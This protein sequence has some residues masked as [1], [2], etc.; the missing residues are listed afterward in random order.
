MQLLTM[1]YQSLRI[2]IAVCY[3]TC[4]NKRQN[5]PSVSV[6]MYNHRKLM[7]RDPCF[8]SWRKPFTCRWS[9]LERVTSATNIWASDS[10]FYD[11]CE[12][13]FNHFCELKRVKVLHG[14][15]SANKED[16]F[17]RHN[18][19]LCIMVPFMSRPN[20]ANLKPTTEKQ[21]NIVF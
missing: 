11:R 17:L 13:H 15:I 12:K 8:S 1:I 16:L 2:L 4:T 3:C 21:M 5:K 19:I 10:V 14:I 9:G 6:L 7:R 20:V 18:L